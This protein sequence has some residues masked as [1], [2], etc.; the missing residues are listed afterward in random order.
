MDM[1]GETP[2][3]EIYNKMWPIYPA[4]YEGPPVK[5]LDGEI[6]KIVL[7]PMEL[8]SMEVK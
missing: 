2:V 5:I 4:K 3:F 1:L 8:L 6:K 7:L